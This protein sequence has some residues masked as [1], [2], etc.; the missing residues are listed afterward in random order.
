MADL[1]PSPSSQRH[2]SVPRWI[3]GAVALVLTCTA[4]GSRLSHARLLVD[5]RGTSA[6][7]PRGQIAAGGP[8]VTPVGDF[9]G[10]GSVAPQIDPSASGA[11]ETN[12]SVA[13]TGPSSK[14]D[15]HADSS[16]SPSGAACSGAKS[17]VVIGSVGEQTG[18]LGALFQGGIKAVQAWVA[19]VNARGGV[20]CHPVRYVV[21][22][23]GGDPARHQAL[24]QQ[25]VEQDHVS[26]FV[27]MDSPLAGQSSVSYITR[28]QIPVIGSEAG[29]Q[30]FYQS[31][32]YF[33]QATSAIPYIETSIASS[34]DLGRPGRLTRFGS[35]TCVEVQICS[36]VYQYEPKFAPKYGLT[37]VYQGQGSIAQ[38]DYTSL[39]Q[40]AESAGVQILYVVLDANGQERVARSC[41]S[42]N[43]HPLYVTS[44]ASIEPSEASDPLLDGLGGAL[45]T[46][47]W[48][49]AA[50][51]SI[52]QFLDV[53]K[54][55]APGVQPFAQGVLGWTSAKLFELAA[56][57]LTEPPTSQSVLEGLWSIKG[58]D[59]G[60]L[61]YPLTFTKGQNAPQTEC[62]WLIQIK[63]GRIISANNGQRTCL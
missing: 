28:A 5:S 21:A 6:E 19:W 12:H 46:T 18:V 58:N 35:I 37:L 47:P 41:H 24:V 54:Q 9:T 3:A 7:F 1:Q 56:Q 25:L 26:A 22:D 23:D 15:N 39:C 30:W 44:T 8:D 49:N 32:V 51:P 43:Y 27:F 10:R 16:V 2:S 57:R 50:N 61:T 36:Q 59:L 53:L 34:A 63:G 33:P 45:S 55:Y 20:S 52:Q 11:L 14:Q 40:A 17:T 31:P 38:P 60:G 48:T 42:I 62:Y 4:C 13:T 29:E